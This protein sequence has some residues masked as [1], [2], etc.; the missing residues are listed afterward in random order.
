MAEEA[1]SED[2]KFINVTNFSSGTW[3]FSTIHFF[4]CAR[5]CPDSP[6]LLSPGEGRLWRLIRSAAS[7]PSPSRFS[8]GGLTG[9]SWCVKNE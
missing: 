9:R 1:I 2:D 5:R 7:R 3:M 4:T 6:S 8:D